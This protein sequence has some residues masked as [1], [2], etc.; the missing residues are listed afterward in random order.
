MFAVDSYGCT[1]YEYIDGEPEFIKLSENF[2]NRRKIYHIPFSTEHCYYMKLQ[3]DG[4][5]KDQA[6]SVTMEKFP[7]L[8][9]DG[10]TKPQHDF[11]PAAHASALKEFTQYITKISVDEPWRQSLSQAQ[12]EKIHLL[13]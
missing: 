9:E 2:Q 4:I 7:S 13:Q 1:P 5:G 11:E 3:N 10:P 12:I 6:V 8:K